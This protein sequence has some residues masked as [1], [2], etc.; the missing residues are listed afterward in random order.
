MQ[1]TAFLYNYNFRTLDGYNIFYSTGI[2]AVTTL[3][4]KMV[5]IIPRVKVIAE[6]ITAVGKINI[7]FLKPKD[8]ISY[9]ILQLRTKQ[10]MQTFNGKHPGYSN[11]KGLLGMVICRWSVKDCAEFLI[12]IFMPMID[13]KS[14]DEI[15]IYST[16]YFASE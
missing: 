7:T 16:L 14:I 15:C 10:K 11:M 3:K 8:M 9:Q 12:N 2:I 6:D 1:N 5:K 4:T 13:L